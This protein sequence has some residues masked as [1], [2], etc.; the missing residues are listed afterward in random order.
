MIPAWFSFVLIGWKKKRAN[1]YINKTIEKVS[2]KI[3]GKILLF[4]TEE[5]LCHLIPLKK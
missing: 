4:R 5:T 3:T 1:V 2:L